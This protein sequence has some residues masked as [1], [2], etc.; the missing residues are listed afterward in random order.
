MTRCLLDPNS[1][2][3]CKV[4]SRSASASH[5]VSSVSVLVRKV[6]YHFDLH[7]FWISRRAWLIWPWHNANSPL[8]SG[9]Q[10]TASV[11]KPLWCQLVEQAEA[12][13][14][15]V[16]RYCGF[17]FWTRLMWFDAKFSFFFFFYLHR[18]LDL[19]R[20]LLWL[21][22]WRTCTISIWGLWVYPLKLTFLNLNN[23]TCFLTSHSND[24]YTFF[25]L[26]ERRITSVTAA[27]LNLC[28]SDTGC[29]RLGV[30]KVRGPS[31]C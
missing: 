28:W 9:D 6:C 20:E 19:R 18:V 8:N 12:E 24:K 2:I 29:D 1:C 3:N 5:A 7:R 26:T 21:S 14:K 22:F 11:N 25:F 10:V 31:L 15:H 13:Q 23:R 30:S 16:S 17:V 27:S 4:T